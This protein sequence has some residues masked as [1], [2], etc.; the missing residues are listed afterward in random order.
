MSQ[1]VTAS[2]TA[3]GNSV[4]L[5]VDNLP[6]NVT[7]AITGTYS[8]HVLNIDKS[9][10]GRGGGWKSVS[11]PHTT[12]NASTSGSAD[13]QPGE[14]LR[15]RVEDVSSGDQVTGTIAVVLTEENRTISILRDV[16]GTPIFIAKEDGV[17][18]PGTLDIT[19]AVEITGALT[20]TGAQTSAAALETSAN[21]GVSTASSVKEYG[22]GYNH[23]TVLTCTGLSFASEPDNASLAVGDLIYAFPAGAVI[24]ES[25]YFKLALTQTGDV[26]T[27]DYDIGLGSIIASGAVSV[28]GGTSTFEDIIDGQTEIGTQDGTNDTVIAA[29]PT[30]GAQL[31]IASGD[32]HNV[33]VNVA[34]VWSDIDTSVL[35]YTGIVVL[36]W[37]FLE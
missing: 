25:A 27:D 24:L 36:N 18:I 22:D 19:G 6:A 8:G 21:V 12:D 28:L 29:I 4:P 35:T 9:S 31:F 37:K 15:V 5:F 33:F 17:E 34:A 32:V 10:A 26:K 1:V 7:W 14:R 30:A 2:I 20:Q 16:H 13:L 11:G 3:A 23:T